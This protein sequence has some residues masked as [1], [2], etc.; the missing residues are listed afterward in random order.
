MRISGTIT[1]TV[2]PPNARPKHRSRPCQ[3]PSCTQCETPVDQKTRH[4]RQ[5]SSVPGNNSFPSRS[6][7]GDWRSAPPAVSYGPL[8]TPKAPNIDGSVAKR[9]GTHIEAHGMRPRSIT[10]DHSTLRPCTPETWH[11]EPGNPPMQRA[12]RRRARRHLASYLAL[13]ADRWDWGEPGVPPNANLVLAEGG[14]TPPA[15]DTTCSVKP[16]QRVIRGRI[17]AFLQC[18]LEPYC[19]FSHFGRLGM[20]DG[21]GCVSDSRLHI[22]SARATARAETP[23]AKERTHVFAAS[24]REKHALAASEQPVWNALGARDA[25]YGE[26]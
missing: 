9:T 12:F 1:R 24:Q 19:P 25:R 20:I 16:P 13:D 11:T 21:G 3:V 5:H 7:T 10:L 18:A 2:N 26:C 6:T 8:K 17:L 15:T 4:T 22:G 14:S 23:R